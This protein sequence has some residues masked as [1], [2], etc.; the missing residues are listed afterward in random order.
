MLSLAFSSLRSSGD[1][2]SHLHRLYSMPFLWKDETIWLRKPLARWGVPQ[3]PFLKVEYDLLYIWQPHNKNNKLQSQETGTLAATNYVVLSISWLSCEGSFGKTVRVKT[4]KPLWK[5][6]ST[7]SYQIWWLLQ[8]QSIYMY[9]CN[10][11][12]HHGNP[13][14]IFLLTLTWGF[15]SHS[16]VWHTHYE[17]I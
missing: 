4:K 7:S 17:Q 16:C 1:S 11:Y 13:E 5:L 14:Y 3:P 15:S 8:P 9:K 12:T 6:S 2:Y 10:A